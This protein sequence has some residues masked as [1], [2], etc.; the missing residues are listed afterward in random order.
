MYFS[1]TAAVPIQ[2]LLPE[3]QGGCHVQWGPSSSPH[4]SLLAPRQ[5]ARS[6]QS[7]PGKGILP[8]FNLT[9]GVLGGEE[10]L[11]L[12]WV[13][14]LYVVHA[15]RSHTGVHLL[16]TIQLISNSPAI[17]WNWS[18]WKL[19]LVQ[20][21][22]LGIVFVPEKASA[23]LAHGL[24]DVPLPPHHPLKPQVLLS[25]LSFSQGLAHVAVLILTI[26]PLRLKLKYLLSER[27][28]SIYLFSLQECLLL[29]FLPPGRTCHPA[30]GGGGGWHQ[31]RPPP[32]PCWHTHR[33]LEPNSL[34][35]RGS[36]HRVIIVCRIGLSFDKNQLGQS[37]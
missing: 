27:R 14:H 15:L 1:I 29:L 37:S 22:Q 25:P 26:V 33:R 36:I 16:I 8:Q 13:G 6:G 18:S 20:G 4:I 12:F 21:Q 34:R 5:T 9:R 10:G 17:Q 24:D 28:L 7:C 2:S 23:I 30:A 32:P 35:G 19:R 3:S 31:A 11:S